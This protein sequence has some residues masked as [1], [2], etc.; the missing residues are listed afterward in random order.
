VLITVGTINASTSS[1]VE[2]EAG[3]VWLDKIVSRG[4]QNVVD[5]F[6]VG[7]PQPI[8]LHSFQVRTVVSLVWPQAERMR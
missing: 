3:G 7:D 5:G 4:L 6:R 1:C 2:R 8:V